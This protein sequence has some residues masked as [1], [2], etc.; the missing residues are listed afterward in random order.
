MNAHVTGPGGDVVK[1]NARAVH[2][3]SPVV[4]VNLNCPNS[5]KGSRNQVIIL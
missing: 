2:V 5:S 4:F 1:K 3:V